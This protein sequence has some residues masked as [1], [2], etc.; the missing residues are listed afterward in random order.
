M[1]RD[2]LA[3]C[4]A[5]FGR[6]PNNPACGAEHHCRDAACRRGYILDKRTVADYTAVEACRDAASAP[7]RLS[8]GDAYAGTRGRIWFP[9]RWLRPSMGPDP[10]GS[11]VTLVASDCLMSKAGRRRLSACFANDVQK[12]AIHCDAA[13]INKPTRPPTNVPLMRIYCR[14]LPTCSSSRSTSV[15]VS[16]LRTTRSMKAPI[17]TR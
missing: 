14:S 11:R 9:L 5:P 16:Q 10:T 3:V 6:Q 13:K 17:S 2:L 15:A 1:V 4:R 7:G 8:G 12:R